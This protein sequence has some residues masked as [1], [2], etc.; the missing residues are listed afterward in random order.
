ML[1]TSCIVSDAAEYYHPYGL[2]LFLDARVSIYKSTI[3]LINLQF[4]YQLKNNFG[5]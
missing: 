3:H 5:L 2:L 4:N 1:R